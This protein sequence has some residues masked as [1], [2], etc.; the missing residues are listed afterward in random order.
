MSAL[1]S[2]MAAVMPAGPAP[3]MT[4]S[5]LMEATV[6]IQYKHSGA[7]WKPSAGTFASCWCRTCRL[8]EDM[9]NPAKLT[10][11]LAVLAAG[12]SLAAEK[13]TEGVALTIYNQNFGVVRERRNVE[14]KEK[15]GTVRFADVATQI[16]GTSVSFKSLTDP[17]ATVLEQNYEYD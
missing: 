6:T 10:A 14:V 4:T 8:E 12:T 16:D 11:L 7:I 5:Y 9:K 2:A 17:A 3:T 1:A 15:E 13:Q